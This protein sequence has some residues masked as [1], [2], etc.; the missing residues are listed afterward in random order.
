MSGENIV[1]IAYDYE[2]LNYKIDKY[3]KMMEKALSMYK[4]RYMASFIL[5]YILL[6]MLKNANFRVCVVVILDLKFAYLY[7][8]VFSID[9]LSSCT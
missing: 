7:R 8:S 4:V 6:S 5:P 3:C 9:K 1:P 2:V